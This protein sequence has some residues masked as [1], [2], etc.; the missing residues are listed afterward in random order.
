MLV[1]VD[2]TAFLEYYHHKNIFIKN[3]EKIYLGA[4][5]PKLTTTN[6]SVM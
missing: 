6:G 1:V 4:S 3:L 2:F 5:Y